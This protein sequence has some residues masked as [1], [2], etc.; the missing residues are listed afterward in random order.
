MTRTLDLMVD[1]DEVIFPLMDSIHQL[2]YERGLHDGTAKQEWAGWKAYGCTEAA[3]WDLWSDFAMAG[4][5]TSTPPYDGAVE[6]LRD[7]HFEGH[8]IHLVTARGFMKNA[9]KIRRW[10]PAWIQEFAV[11]HASL[12]FARNK[13]HAMK[14]LGV[15]FDLALDDSPSNF[16]T[17]QDAGVH[18]WLQSHPHNDGFETDF[19]VGSVAEFAMIAK[20]LVA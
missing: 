4:G 8:R 15:H 14:E 17:L 10:T 12:T 7:L 16:Q 13:A 6:A 5:Y 19:R 20:R 18:A 11:P 3:Y 2:A 1:I 9:S